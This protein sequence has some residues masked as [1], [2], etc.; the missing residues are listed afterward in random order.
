MPGLV[1]VRTARLE[2]DPNVIPLI[3]VLLVVLIAYMLSLRIRHVIDTQVPP[4]TADVSAPRVTQIVLEL[5][6][7]E[8]YAI[9]GQPVPNEA[10]DTTL[11]EIF[12]NRQAKLLFIKAASDR[13]YQEVVDA[14]DRS[15]GSG[16]EVIALAPR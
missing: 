11:R 5:L 3:D 6:P 14:M 9:N 12:A 2:S 10:L 7:G 8:G 4:A 13:R 16:V 1:L 15:R